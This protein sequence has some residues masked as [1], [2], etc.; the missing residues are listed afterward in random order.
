MVTEGKSQ[1]SPRSPERMLSSNDR[2]Q[3]G[4]DPEAELREDMRPPP[5]RAP[6]RGGALG[7]RG[8]SGGGQGQGRGGGALWGG[9]KQMVQAPF[10]RCLPD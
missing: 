5:P 3:T 10:Q 1:D 6:G 9:G 2:P 8:P 7:V 4:L